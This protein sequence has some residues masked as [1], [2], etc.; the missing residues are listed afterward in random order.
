M[1]PGLGGIRCQFHGAG[2]ERLGLVQ[3]A[4]GGEE[5]AVD[6]QDHKLIWRQ[7]LGRF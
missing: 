4:E 6:A 5:A 1:Q 7:R 3:P 2:G